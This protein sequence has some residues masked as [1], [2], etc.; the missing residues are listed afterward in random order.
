MKDLKEGII[1]SDEGLPQFVVEDP[2][3]QWMRTAK[4]LEEESPILVRVRRQVQLAFLETDIQ[5]DQPPHEIM[6]N[7]WLHSCLQALYTICQQALYSMERLQVF[8]AWFTL[9]GGWLL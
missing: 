7:P 5:I 1:T 8:H 2:D 4:R 6:A 3:L 9:P